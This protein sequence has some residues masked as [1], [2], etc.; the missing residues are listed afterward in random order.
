M[1][2]RIVELVIDNLLTFAVMGGSVVL[3]RANSRCVL[4]VSG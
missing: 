2:F 4:V 3:V 1:M